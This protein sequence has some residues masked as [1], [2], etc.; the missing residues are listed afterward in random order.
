M[1]GMIPPWMLGIEQPGAKD[2]AGGPLLAYVRRIGAIRQTLSY[3]LKQIIDLEL[4]LN[5]YYEPEQRQYRIIFPKLWTNPQSQSVQAEGEEEESGESNSPGI[6]D[7]DAT[8]EGFRSLLKNG[9]IATNGH[10]SS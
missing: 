10:R 3:G 4:I 5:G 8:I 6:A 1:S 2:I 9:E 7:L